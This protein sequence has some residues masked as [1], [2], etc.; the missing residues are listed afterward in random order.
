MLSVRSLVLAAAGKYIAD[1]RD[2]N[3]PPH[4]S[5]EEGAEARRVPPPPIGQCTT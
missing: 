3:T 4:R 1:R 2:V 5:R